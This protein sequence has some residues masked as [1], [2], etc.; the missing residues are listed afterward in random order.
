MSDRSKGL[1]LDVSLQE[2][3][4]THCGYEFTMLDVQ[5]RMHPEISSF[6]SRQ[7]Y[8]SQLRDGENV[9][10]ERGRRTLLI[11]GRPYSFLQ[12][13][14]TEIK[15]STQSTCNAMEANAV[16]DLVKELVHESEQYRSSVQLLRITTFY[17]AQK[18]IRKMLDNGGFNDV[19]VATVDSSQGCEADVV[20]VSLVRSVS[21]G[22]LKD[23]RRMNVALTRARYQL[24]C[25]GNVARYSSMEA[26]HTLHHFTIDARDHNAIV[27]KEICIDRP[28]KRIK[29]ERI[30][31]LGSDIFVN[32]TTKKT[33][34]EHYWC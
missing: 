15:G 16:V 18:H 1:C 3:L 19:L 8:N 31:L 2:R 30:E 9:M 28:V 24:V 22:F 27:E 34:I 29:Q 6:P 32:G 4:V 13:N 12:V 25:I 26:A 17:T 20:I 33:H 21:A 11:S 10:V 14:G 5:Y 23:D 7:F